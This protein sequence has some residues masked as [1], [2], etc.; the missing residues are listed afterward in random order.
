MEFQINSINT[1]DFPLMARLHIEISMMVLY[2]R[3]GISAAF[4]FLCKPINWTIYWQ[5]IN[6]NKHIN[7]NTTHRESE[8]EKSFNQLN[9]DRF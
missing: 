4:Y 6:W 7:T 3:K 9:V 1:V 2:I 8:E 5:H